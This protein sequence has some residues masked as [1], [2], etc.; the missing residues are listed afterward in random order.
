M[1][2]EAIFNSTAQVSPAVLLS[3]HRERTI[4]AILEKKQQLHESKHVF[5]RFHLAM[6]ELERFLLRSEGES[7]ALD[8][9]VMYMKQHELAELNDLYC[10]W[11]TQLERCF[12][13]FLDLNIVGHFVDYPLYAR[14][15]R[16]INRE[17]GLLD[18]NVPRKMLFIG[19]GPMPITALCLRHRLPDTEI[20]CLERFES[21]V[22][23]SRV[24]M[25]KLGFNDSIHVIQGYGEKVDVS[26][27]D[28]I[29]VALLAK[30]KRAIL[31]NLVRTMRDDAWL[32]CRTSFGSRTVFYEPTLDTAVPPELEVQR[33]AKAGIDDTI[34]SVLLR[35]AMVA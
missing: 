25:N 2:A 33:V 18:G 6:R 1:H 20:H 10:Q 21:A 32:I 7:E 29:L 28:A 35:K 31:E 3:G 15:E 4:H 23:E 24:V 12:V 11:E 26:E 9:A 34:S 19:S 5:H 22:Q 14:F 17:V 8:E 13:N 27:Y 30:P 16:L